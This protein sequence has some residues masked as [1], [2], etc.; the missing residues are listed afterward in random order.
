MRYQLYH[1]D[2]GNHIIV[3]TLLDSIIG[4]IRNQK[5]ALRLC[6][7]LNRAVK[8]ERLLAKTH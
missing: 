3:D 5:Q 7:K 6:Q 4:K 2:I 1:D 8:E